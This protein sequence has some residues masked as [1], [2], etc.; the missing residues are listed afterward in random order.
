MR[1]LFL[2]SLVLVACG[3]TPVVRASVKAPP[4]PPPPTPSSTAAAP[5]APVPGSI[6]PAFAFANG[7]VVRSHRP[8]AIALRASPRE[9][10]FVNLEADAIAVH[11]GEDGA[12]GVEADTMADAFRL[13]G[14]V[15]R[16][17]VELFAP[18]V[19]FGD[20]L[21]TTRDV[22]WQRTDPSGKVSL[23]VDL[24]ENVLL[25]GVGS[26][27]ASTECERV[28]LERPRRRRVD[29]SPV[30]FRGDLA[31]SPGGAPRLV[32]I[33][34]SARIINANGKSVRVVVE[35]GEFL[36]YGW[37]PRSKVSENGGIGLGYGGAIG[38]SGGRG[39][40]LGPGAVACP[41]PLTIYG[42]MADRTIADV[43]VYAAGAPF[44]RGATADAW[45]TVRLGPEDD[46][47]RDAGWIVRESD[48]AACGAPAIKRTWKL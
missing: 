19:L 11:L 18:D 33:A 21:E 34:G 48:L 44:V 14:Y 20:M 25:D 2:A 38:H 40:G 5:P 43:G 27:S 42:R 32:G 29:P 26:A 12:M 16:D 1:A 31:S 35:S 22:R 41:A 6:R 36:A 46:P 7:C 9:A 13:H 4:A 45:V 23:S 8:R 39:Y 47:L 3:G 17:T 15:P 24:P 30:W 28:S 37:T 10:P